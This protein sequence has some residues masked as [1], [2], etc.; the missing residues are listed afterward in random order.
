M[1][2][3]KFHVICVATQWQ[4]VFAVHICYHII[5][6][7]IACLIKLSVDGSAD[8]HNL[9]Q[10]QICKLHIYVTSCLGDGHER[11]ISYNLILD[12]ILL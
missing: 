10:N 2:F 9:E 4:A 3:R 7:L 8:F 12:I 6:I 1:P 11:G 5:I